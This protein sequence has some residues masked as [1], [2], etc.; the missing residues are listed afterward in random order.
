MA[1][2]VREFCRN[3]TY[4]VAEVEIEG[5]EPKVLYKTLKSYLAHNQDMCRGVHV[6]MRSGRVFLYREVSR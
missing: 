4:D 2:D 6:A 1:G 3:R 5:H